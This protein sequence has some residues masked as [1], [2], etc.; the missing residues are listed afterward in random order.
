MAFAAALRG[1][2]RHGAADA[3]GLSLVCATGLFVCVGVAKAVNNGADKFSVSGSGVVAVTGTL[4]VSSAAT[5]V[6]M[7]TSGS[8]VRV[9]AGGLS[10]TAGGLSVTAGGLT[11]T[12]GGLQVGC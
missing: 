3:V 9:N 6:G 5:I 8:G 1:P 11:V 12:A 4:S 10:V 2:A 7:L